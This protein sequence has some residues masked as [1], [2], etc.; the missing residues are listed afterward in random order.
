MES[1]MKRFDPKGEYIQTWIRDLDEYNKI[2]PIIKDYKI[3][4]KEGIEL[5]KEAYSNK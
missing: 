5:Y 3:A 2:Q 4:R 1:Q